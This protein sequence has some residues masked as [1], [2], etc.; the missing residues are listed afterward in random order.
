M[1]ADE[2][3]KALLEVPRRAT[4]QQVALTLSE[5]YADKDEKFYGWVAPYQDENTNREGGAIAD[6]IYVLNED[7]EIYVDDLPV[8]D[9]LFKSQGYV[10]QDILNENKK[11]TF[12]DSFRAELNNASGLG[13]FVFTG[14]WTLNQIIS[15]AEGGSLVI[16]KNVTCGIFNPVTGGGSLLGVELEK[17]WEIPSIDLFGDYIFPFNINEEEMGNWGCSIPFVY[18]SKLGQ[19]TTFTIH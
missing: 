8:F 6:F 4:A 18:G 15:T 19:D 16:P 5:T 11:G 13:V 12:L 3:R 10:V 1:S 9:K 14:T 7:N 2:I 17:D